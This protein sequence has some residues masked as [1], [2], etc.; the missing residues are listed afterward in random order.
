MLDIAMRPGVETYTNVGHAGGRSGHG[1]A[2][3][4]ATRPPG[5]DRLCLN[6]RSTTNLVINVSGENGG[7]LF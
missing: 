6:A 1:P 3:S 4:T 5:I 2:I 7:R